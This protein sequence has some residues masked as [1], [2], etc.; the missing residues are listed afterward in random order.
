MK[1]LKLFEE[2]D[3]YDMG[4]IAN[5]IIYGMG[6]ITIQSLKPVYSYYNDDPPYYRSDTTLHRYVFFK[7]VKHFKNVLENGMGCKGEV[8]RCT[9]ADID[10]DFQQM[11]INELGVEYKFYILFRINFNIDDIILS[12]N[13]LFDDVGYENKWEEEDEVLVKCVKLEPEWIIESGKLD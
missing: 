6:E 9:G 10:E 8:M 3:I 7:D 1:Y 12:V 13:D 4:E 5:N 2:Y 11:M